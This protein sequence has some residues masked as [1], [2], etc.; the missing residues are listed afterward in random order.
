MAI[1]RM[2]LG[3][4]EKY[5]FTVLI[6]RLAD[7]LGGWR[8]EVRLKPLMFGRPTPSFGRFGRI[9][10]LSGCQAFHAYEPSNVVAK[11]L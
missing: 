10:P 8:S 3:K 5:R 11:V 1:D 9:P 6:A 2:A 7:F 4:L